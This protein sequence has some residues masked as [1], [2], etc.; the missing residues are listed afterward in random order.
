MAQREYYEDIIP[1]IEG[2]L[3]K[4]Y[5]A[6]EIYKNQIINNS[7]QSLCNARK[8]LITPVFQPLEKKIQN[9]LTDQY[10]AGRFEEEDRSE[11]YTVN[12]ERVRSKSEMLI[13]NLLYRYD[14]PYRYEKPIELLDWNKVIICRPDFTIMNRR[15]GKIYIYEHLGKMDDAN[16]VENNMHKLNLYEKNGYLIGKNLIITRETSKE[17]LN[18][19]IVESYIQ[20][21]FL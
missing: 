10:P 19:A 6:D 7:Y 13:S 5:L 20:E 2:M 9:F 12:G 4:L 18:T 11:F 21:F 1:V 17:P 8:N 16:Y 15:T 3:T 14:V